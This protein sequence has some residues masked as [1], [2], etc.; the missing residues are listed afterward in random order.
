MRLL[1]HKY[2][3]KM[4]LYRLSPY[5]TAFDAVEQFWVWIPFQAHCTDYTLKYK[6]RVEVRN[7]G[8][9]FGLFSLWTAFKQLCQAC[10][11]LPAFQST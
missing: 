6:I 11:F 2:D 3:L 8:G 7:G 5:L 4:F 1:L 10:F 9:H